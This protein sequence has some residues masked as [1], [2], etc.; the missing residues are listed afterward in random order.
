MSHMKK[1]ITYNQTVLHAVP[2]VMDTSVVNIKSVDLMDQHV[3]PLV[4]LTTT[5]LI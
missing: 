5:L 4:I 3:M 1:E 2:V